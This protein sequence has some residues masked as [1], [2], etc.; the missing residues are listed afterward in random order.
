MI[1]FG[2]KFTVCACMIKY[3][4]SDHEIVEIKWNPFVEQSCTICGLLLMDKLIENALKVR[5]WTSF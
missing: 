3:P 4:I 1:F 2:V 5:F